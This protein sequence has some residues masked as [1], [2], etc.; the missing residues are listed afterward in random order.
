VRAC[1]KARSNEADRTSGSASIRATRSSPSIASRLVPRNGSS[2]FSTSRAT[3]G[4]VP[5]TRTVSIAN[6]EVVR[7]AAYAA[8]APASRA[9]PMAIER[10][11]GR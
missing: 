4:V 3:A 6:N 1:G 8:A 2:S 10:P 11:D 9:R 7:A 5:S